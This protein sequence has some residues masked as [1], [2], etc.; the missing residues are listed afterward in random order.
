MDYITISG[1]AVGLA[2]DATA[3]AVAC[4]VALGRVTPRQVFRLSFH[5]G[6]FQALMPLV[7]WLAGKTIAPK[8]EAW[9][10]WIAFGLLTAIGIRAIRGSLLDDAGEDNTASDPTRGLSLVS[11]SVATSI[12]ALAV[13]LS[14]ALLR[15]T[16]WQA[17]VLIGAITAALTIGGM[18]L[19]SRLGRSLG[20]RMEA[21]GGVVLILVGAKIDLSHL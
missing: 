10:H 8:I 3:V 7:G 17:C 2:M 20:R 1:I 11:L 12:D 21:V 5:F 6:L 15:V 19:G 9:D 4:S 18:L 16:V 13:G 14:F